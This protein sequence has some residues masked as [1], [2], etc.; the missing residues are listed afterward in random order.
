[1][2]YLDILDWNLKKAI[3]ALKIITL[4][5]VK[6][7]NIVL[8]KKISNLG[9]KMPYLW[10]VNWKSNYHIWNQGSRSFQDAKFFGKKKFSN[11]RTKR[12][13]ASFF[14][15][16]LKIMVIL[17][18]PTLIYLSSKFLWKI[19]IPLSWREKLHNMSVFSLQFEKNSSH[20]WN[21][22]LEIG[23][24]SISNLYNEFLHRIQFFLRSRVHLF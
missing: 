8:N 17:K 22:H 7:L 13:C 9:Q 20:V 2:P 16:I 12:T 14:W 15:E 19:K 11:L 10:A 6:I 18:S 1:M 4:N 24:K 23:Q 3:G 21:K 5:F